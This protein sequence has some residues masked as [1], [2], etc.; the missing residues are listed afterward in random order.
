MHL[1]TT[2]CDN[3][4]MFPGE[5]VIQLKG[6]VALI[7]SFALFTRR[8]QKLKCHRSVNVLAFSMQK[9]NKHTV[10]AL[11]HCRPFRKFRSAIWWLKHQFNIRQAK[12]GNPNA[13]YQLGPA[14]SL[15][16]VNG[17]QA[18]VFHHKVL[19]RS[20]SVSM[21]NKKDRPPLA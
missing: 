8:N 16:C 14:A 2:K 11:W 10:V 15:S 17:R 12:G 1:G 20:V 13:I 18:R 6:P 9:E 4:K 21:V 3:S 7:F 5:I 19:S